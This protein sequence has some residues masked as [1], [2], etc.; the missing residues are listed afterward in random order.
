[1]KYPSQVCWHENIHKQGEDHHQA[2]E[3]RRECG[4]GEGVGNGCD[5]EVTV[6]ATNRLAGPGDSAKVNFTFEVGPN[7]CERSTQMEICYPSL[8]P[9]CSSGVSFL[10]P[11]SVPLPSLPFLM[12]LEDKYRVT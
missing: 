6:C 8:S 1:M 3:G 5:A 9:K 4:D 10:L 2:G 11:F 12:Y 7:L